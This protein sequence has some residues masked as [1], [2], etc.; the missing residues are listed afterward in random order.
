MMDVIEEV[1]AKKVNSFLVETL[2]Q[3]DIPAA[4]VSGAE[5]ILHC[6][7]AD[8]KLEQVGKIEK[9][10]VERIYELLSSEKI[11]IPVIAPI[12]IGRK[13]KKYNINADWAAAKIA[14]A[15][16]AKKL[17]FITDQNG[18]LDGEKNLISTITPPIIEKLIE[19]KVITGGMFTKVNTMLAALKQGIHEVCVLNSINASLS[20]T[21]KNLGT[22]LVEAVA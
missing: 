9:V 19:E 1:L 4:G 6:T 16:G 10:C 15:L 11:T 3:G 20:L 7:Q 21:E 8:R 2:K 14:T 18:I 22:T 5:S 13:N 17:I 12:G